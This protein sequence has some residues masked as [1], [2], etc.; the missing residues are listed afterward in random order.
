MLITSVL[1]RIA[2]LETDSSPVLLFQ[3][4]RP[5][6]KIHSELRIIIVEFLFCG[7]SCHLVNSLS[8]DKDVRVK[9]KLSKNAEYP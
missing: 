8:P 4:A 1:Y 7:L 5:I 6:S 2:R 3:I 9:C